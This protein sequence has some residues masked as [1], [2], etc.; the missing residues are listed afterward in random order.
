MERE[1]QLYYDIMG[2]VAQVCSNS[3]EWLES[4]GNYLSAKRISKSAALIRLDLIEASACEADACVPL[5]GEGNKTVELT[6]FM[7]RDILFSTYVVGR[8]RWS[9]FA[10]YGRLYIDY[11]AGR[12][13]A[14]RVKDSGIS[15]QYADILLAY[16][17]LGSLLAK[18]GFYDVHAS[19]VQVG[20]KGVLFTGHSGR[21]KSSAGYAMARKGHPILTDEKI[22]ICKQGEYYGVSISDVIKLSRQAAESF[23]PELHGRTPLFEVEGELCFKVSRLN[24]IKHITETALHCLFIMEQTGEAPSRVEK[25]NP[26]RVVGDLLPVTLRGYEPDNMNE[27]FNFLMDLLNSVE[28]YRVYFG[29]D[30]DHFARIIEEVVGG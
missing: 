1:Y 12:A 29:T 14:V 2:R 3:K 26:A 23:F 24:G 16:N 28:C 17:P 7:E 6:V 9:D 27:K 19:C 8:K 4:F 11:D 25:I 20:G 5:P 22:L 10:G 21:G 15:P 18:E 13:V 30:M